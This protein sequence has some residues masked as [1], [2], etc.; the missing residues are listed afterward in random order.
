MPT[1]TLVSKSLAEVGR[2]FYFLGPSEECTDCKLNGVCFN[3]E[4]GSKYRVIE[5]RSQVHNCHEFDDDSAVAVVVEKVSVA[6]SIPKKGALE[7]IVTMFQEPKCGNIGCDNYRICHPVGTADGCKYKV[8][9]LGK[10][11]DCPIG[12]KRVYAELL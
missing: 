11:I 9:S 4:D 12:E 3:L 5:V 1:I 10:D 6:A 8:V 2:E 7:G